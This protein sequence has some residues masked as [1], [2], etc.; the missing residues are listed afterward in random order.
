MRV[1]G[2]RNALGKPLPAGFDFHAPPYFVDTVTTNSY[3]L[4][5]PE[6]H[7]S[8]ASIIRP[9]LLVSLKSSV[10]GGVTYQRVELEVDAAT[11][12][13]EAADVQRW[14]TTKTV[15]DKEEH[16]RATKCRSKALGLIRKVCQATSFGLLCPE[17][18][19]GALDAAVTAARQLV[20]AHNE[21]A[22]STR[23]GLYV[24]KGRVASN[25]AEA[26][27]AITSEIAGL[28]IQMTNGINTFDPKAIREAADKARELSAMLSEDKQEKVNAAIAQARAAARTIVKRIQNEGEARET[29]L[30]DIQRG[31][32]ESARIAFL[33]MSG[34]PTTGETTM[35]AVDAQR[36][37]D[38]DVSNT[39][40]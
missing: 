9:G 21:S 6:A 12:A 39:E 16:E 38:L 5:R 36:F 8:N 28:V 10:A 23:V 40:H 35:P 11:A 24:I 34:D 20:D 1:N 4:N 32:I 22:S 2:F 27:K 14:E 13:G 7:M 33:D 3:N 37:A 31:Q 29:V 30:L 18:Q 15:D 19:E 26:A 17:S 25:D